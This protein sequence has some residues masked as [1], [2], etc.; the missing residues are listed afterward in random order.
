MRNL[1][2]ARIFWI[3]AAAILVVA[4]LV[5]LVAVL[6]GDFSDT[7]GRILGTLAALFYTGGGLLAG[8]ALVDSRRAA[9]LGRTL[10]VVSPL[11]LAATLRAIWEWVGD[12]EDEEHW[13]L[14]WS[15]SIALAAGLMA[16]TSLLLARKLA[17]VRL[18]WASGA[19]AAAAAALSVVAI[20][21]EDPGDAMGK[22]L[23]ALWI[24]AVLAYFLV[25]VLE[26]FLAPAYDT[27][28]RLLAELDGVELVAT[29]SGPGIEPRLAAGERLALRRRV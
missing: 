11:V 7:D 20:W 3:G 13:E 28:E 16:A 12:G 10:V 4:A 9:W 19:L 24:L 6:R 1:R 23:A 21:D 26:R 25:P 5:A 27:G 22:V 2:L 29:K 8:L 14:A 17:L 15:A 18:A